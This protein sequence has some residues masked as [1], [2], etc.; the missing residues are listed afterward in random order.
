MALSGVTT[1]NPTALDIYQEVL[2]ILQVVGDGETITTAM[3][4]KITPSMNAM[5]KKWEGQGLHLWTYTEG[6][7]FLQVGQA[8]YDFTDATTNVTN[9]FFPTTTTADALTGASTVTL[10]DVSNVADTD[11]I[12]ILDATNNLFW[13]TVNGAPVGNVVTLTDV[14]PSDIASGSIVYT[15]KAVSLLTV[16][17]IL[18]VRRRE[19]DDYEI[20]I[21]FESRE[22]YFNLP[23][24]SQTG[25]PIQAYYSRQ[26]PEGIMYLWPSP[27][28]SST[29]I[30]FTYERETNIVTDDADTFD[31]PSY[32]LEALTYGIARRCMLKFATSPERAQVITLMADEFLNEALAF[33]DAVYPIE[34]KMQRYA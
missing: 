20:P 18:D 15:Y 11:N 1:L 21:N 22:D 6:S 19:S 30:N 26:E 2:E 33:D 28:S 27:I 29:V 4:A 7:L 31:L 32:W 3:K 9:E 17:R 25:L 5:L 13:T 10:A 14:L 24:K 16:R 34:V 23:N 8:E 12:G